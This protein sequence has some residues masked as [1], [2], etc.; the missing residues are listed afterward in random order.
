[1]HT[2]PCVSHNAFNLLNDLYTP[3]PKTAQA[4]PAPCVFNHE[5]SPST[6]IETPTFLGS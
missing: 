2:R 3:R 6:K 4:A 1:M 5:A